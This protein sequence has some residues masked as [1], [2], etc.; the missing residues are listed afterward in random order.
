M[1]RPEGD[2][3]RLTAMTELGNGLQDGKRHEEALSVEEASLSMKQRI[4]ESEENILIA[5]NNLRPRQTT[6]RGSLVFPL[7]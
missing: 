4:G 5:Q 3:F 2:P 1:G 6:P 7:A